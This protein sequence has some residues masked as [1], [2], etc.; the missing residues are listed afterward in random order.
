MEA[1]DKPWK[2]LKT[3]DKRCVKQASFVHIGL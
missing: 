2:T 3:V 1:M